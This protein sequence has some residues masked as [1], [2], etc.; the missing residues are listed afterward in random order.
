MKQWYELLFENYAKKYDQEAFVHGTLGE[1]DFIE[2]EID[3]DKSVRI[4]DIGCGTGRHAIELAKR[5]YRVTGV[6]LSETLLA[7][8]REK[9]AA[10]GVTVHFRRHDAREL[11]FAAEFDLAIMICEG[12]FSLMETGIIFCL[13]RKAWT[14]SLFLT[15]SSP[16]LMSP[17]VA[18]LAL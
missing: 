17:P 16:V 2:N 9:A 14:S 6:D 11:P 18:G 7:R 12:A 13:W 1:C 10:A 8:A 4:L 15:S 5:G 3:R